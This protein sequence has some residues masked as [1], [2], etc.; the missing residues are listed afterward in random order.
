M[1]DFY[2][3]AGLHPVLTFFLGLIALGI[4]EALAEMVHDATFFL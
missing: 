2:A 3:F 4:F 1:K